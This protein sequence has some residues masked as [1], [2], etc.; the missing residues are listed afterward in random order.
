MGGGEVAVKPAVSYMVGRA[1]KGGSPTAHSR[2]RIMC[3]GGERRGRMGAL[4]ALNL[5]P[6]LL[7]SNKEVRLDAALESPPHSLFLSLLT[8]P[9]AGARGCGAADAK[10]SLLLLLL[11][12]AVNTLPVPLTLHPSPDTLAT[13]TQ[14]GGNSVMVVVTVVVIEVVTVVVVADVCV[15]V[16]KECVEVEFSEVVLVVEVV[17]GEAEVVKGGEGDLEA[18]APL[19][20]SSKVP[21]PSSLTATGG[22]RRQR[23]AFCA[24]RRPPSV[25]VAFVPPLERRPHLMRCM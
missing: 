12:E 8:N 21:S 3:G 22:K 10:V 25:P 18:K 23:C 4:K 1:V 13:C 9:K 24:A 6:S 2:L 16:E 7:N 17:V 11:G 15:G 20:P 19:S 5:S 14:M